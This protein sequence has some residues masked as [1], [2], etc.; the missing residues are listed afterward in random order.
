LAKFSFTRLVNVGGDAGVSAAE[1]MVAA[2]SNQ[3]DA[4]A[5]RRMRLSDEG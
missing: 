1:T 2:K 3:K 4:T 5:V